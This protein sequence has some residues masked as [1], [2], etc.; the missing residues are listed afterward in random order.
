MA[1]KMGARNAGAVGPKWNIN[2]PFVGFSAFLKALPESWPQLARVWSAQSYRSSFSP[3]CG[4][5]ERNQEC[6]LLPA[7][8]LVVLTA[9]F[10]VAKKHHQNSSGN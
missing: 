1:L 5:V 6:R 10:A 9:A 8:K 7:H 2:G 3:C 4:L